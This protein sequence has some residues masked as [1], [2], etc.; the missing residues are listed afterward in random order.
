MNIVDM[1]V[2][3]RQ[4]LLSLRGENNRQMVA[5]LLAT[6]K[7]LTRAA[8][9]NQ[10][11]ELIALLVDLTDSTRDLYM[12]KPLNGQLPTEARIYQVAGKSMAVAHAVAG[13]ALLPIEPPHS[14]EDTQPLDPEV[15]LASIET[16][17]EK[18][19]RRLTDE[20]KTR[21]KAVDD[22]DWR[23]HSAI[24]DGS[25]SQMR[26]Y[27]TVYDELAI[28]LRLQRHDPMWVGTF[29]I[30]VDVETSDI[31]IICNPANLRAFIHDVR[32]AYSFKEGFKLTW[33]AVQQIPTIIVRFTCNDFL[34]ELFAQPKSV[35]EQMA[36]IHM[37][38]E[39]RLLAIGGES[40]KET[41]RELKRGGLKT[42][43]AFAVHFGI[44][45]ENP[46]QS[47]ITLSQMDDESLYRQITY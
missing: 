8:Y 43:P 22:R 15:I 16:S 14:E 17:Q 13:Q 9:E 12:G 47:L 23:E 10:D 7:M 11:K 6:F 40:S 4:Q 42:E 38:V 29:P 37:L 24:R 32:A 36:Y 33:K 25:E 19:A 44:G 39:A 27:S 26:A 35:E 21:L 5:E 31:D 2:F 34:I 46:Y 3:L 1:I 20:M 18:A 41:I 45:G 30:D 28:F